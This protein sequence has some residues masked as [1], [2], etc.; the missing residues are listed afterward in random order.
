MATTKILGLEITA[1]SASYAT[2]SSFALAVAGGGAA[3]PFT[4]SARIT[5]SLG[6][7]GSLSNGSGN[8]ATGIFSHAEG[9]STTSSGSY[10]HAEGSITTAKGFASHAEGFVTTASGSNSHAEGAYTTAKGVSSH[11]EGYGT[12]SSGSYSHA[13][14]GGNSQYY[15]TDIAS[16]TPPV[17]ARGSYSHAEGY[18]Y[19]NVYD[20]DGEVIED[21]RLFASGEA[22][23]AEGYGT[24][25]KG[26]YSHA[27]GFVTTTNAQSSHAEGSTTTANGAHSHAEGISTTST[28]VG[29]HAEGSGTTA[30]G[31]ASHAEGLLTT[32][33]GNYQHVQGQYNLTSSVESAFIHGNGTSLI[34]KSN[35]IFAAGSTVQISGS[36]LGQ[37]TPASVASNTASL[38][39]TGS[40]FFTVSLTNAANTHINPTNLN[41]GQT[42]NIRVTQGN[43]GTGTVSFPSIVKQASGAAYTG[44]A[45]ANAVDIVTMIT[46]DT[47]TVYVSSIRNMI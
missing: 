37:V 23:H 2:T 15:G 27:E 5:G 1:L 6:V 36:L 25:A 24:Q 7:T 14:G 39:L 34:A 31:L 17:E 40:N 46:F 20:N 32:A 42:V 9:Q 19:Y 33:T 45:V 26:A 18:G 35:L 4:G 43:A 22:S 3:F 12:T 11:A 47:S 29:S 44:S 13:E 28:G 41:P 21:F 30:T 38:N 16:T 10:S 8:I